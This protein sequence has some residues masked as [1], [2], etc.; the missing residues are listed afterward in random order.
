MFAVIVV[1]TF[2]GHGPSPAKPEVLLRRAADKMGGEAALVAVRSKHASMVS[3][4][5][6]N[7]LQEEWP[8]A[9]HPIASRDQAWD[10]DWSGLRFR[11]DRA[12]PPHL[13][14]TFSPGNA[15]F[16]I[17]TTQSKL[18]PP[19]VA[20]LQTD[21]MLQSAERVMQL[22]L[23]TPPN[24][25]RS[26]GTSTI[27]GRPVSG[28]RIPL[29]ATSDT[30]T[31]WFDDAEGYLNATDMR[32]NIGGYRNAIYRT[33]YSQWVHA[34]N[35]MIPSFVR[36]SYNNDV[37]WSF[38]LKKAEFNVPLDDSLFRSKPM[39]NTPPP[40]ATVQIQMYGDNV[41]RLSGPTHSSVAVR[42]G[43]HTIVLEAPAVPEQT[44]AMLDSLHA[45]W[46]QAPVADVI[47]THHHFD[48][49]GGI[50]PVFKTSALVHG[51]P[52]ITA[53]LQ[54]F[55]VGMGDPM[56]K[57]KIAAL[58]DSTTFAGGSE[59]VVVYRIPNT[60]ARG[61]VVAYIPSQK[62]LF[63]ADLVTGT[64]M[65]Q[66]ELRDFVQE[67]RLDVT[68]VAPVHGPAMLWSDFVAKIK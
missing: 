51:S 49:V 28:I 24:A 52:D 58:R 21:V 43:N 20:I 56:P 7:L 68:T 61:L 65:N 42:E 50:E 33:E 9:P 36:V 15:L 29:P 64:P 19:T 38:T 27:A 26:A 18:S 53:F 30:V 46:P 62:L 13:L 32:R 59:R 34:G 54:S 17:D 23:V 47:V 55:A 8:G 37:A 12:G 11:I 10:I 22:A 67:K 63:E 16:M 41:M 3:T 2:L 66:R 6:A 1:A 40:P 45:H 44:I 35:L 25:I 5:T 57:R 60:H 4:V 31:L 39:D 48:H 14:Y